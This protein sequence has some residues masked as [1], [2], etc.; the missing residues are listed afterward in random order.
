MLVLEAEELSVDSP[1]AAEAL[2]SAVGVASFV[3]IGLELG[4]W[5]AAASGT[6]ASSARC[7]EL[8]T[9]KQP[10]DAEILRLRRFGSIWEWTSYWEQDVASDMIHCGQ[11]AA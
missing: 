8:V 4:H 5:P 7:P 10:S 3:A 1:E 2:V 11:A 9:P 6:F